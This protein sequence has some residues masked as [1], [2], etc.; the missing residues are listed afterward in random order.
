LHIENG[1]KW[2]EQQQNAQSAH[3]LSLCAQFSQ[4]LWPRAKFHLF[5]RVVKKVC[6]KEYND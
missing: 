6:S 5:A 1:A 4:P 2:K 3:K